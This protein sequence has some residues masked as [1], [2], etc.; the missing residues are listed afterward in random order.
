MSQLLEILGKAITVDTAELIWYWL[1]AAGLQANDKERDQLTRLDKAIQLVSEMKHGEATEQL[2]IHLFEKPACIHGRLAAVGICLHNGRLQQAIDEL[3]SVYMRQPTNTMALYALGHCYERLGKE[4][5]AIE[6]YQDC[7][8]FKRYLELPAQRLAAIYYKNGRIDRAI[9]QYEILQSEYPEDISTLIT[10]GHLYMTEGKDEQAMATFNKAILMHPDNF[11]AEDDEADRLIAEGQLYEAIEQIDDYLRDQPNR[12]DLLLRRADVLRMLGSTTDAVSQYEAVVRMCPNLLEGAIK[13][14][15]QYL[16]MDQDEPAAELFNRAV[17]INDKIVDAYI[18]LASS[19]KSAGAASDALGTLSLAAA[20]Q[21]NSSLLLA[22][23]A[24]LRYKAGLGECLVSQNGKGDSAALNQAVIVAHCQQ[25]A[26]RPQN[27]DLRYRLGV[28]MLNVGRIE[29]ATKSFEAALEVNPLYARARNK[30]AI[31]LFEA[32]RKREALDCLP[33]RDR[34]DKDTLDLHYK[35]AL[36]YCHR[37][38]FASSLLNLEHHLEKNFAHSDATVNI[39]VI[40]QNLGLIDRVGA[41]WDSLTE[42]ANQA[43][44]ADHPFSS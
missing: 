34:L 13:L 28:L 16:Q 41:M 1:D 18:G 14:G 29:D 20:I 9:E 30:L 32:D 36:L 11:H 39:S 31:C 12:T 44:G 38:K 43:I 5:Q 22:E 23:T 4:S 35:T 3:N 25:V 7:L 6:F 15:T 37:L 33:G 2:R 21:P 24:N 27:S 19:Q 10:L 42:T 8:K 17:E 26:Q 40:L